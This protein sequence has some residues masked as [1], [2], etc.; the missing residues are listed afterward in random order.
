MPVA[1][2]RIQSTVFVPPKAPIAVPIVGCSLEANRVASNNDSFLR[3][4]GRG[5]GHVFGAY[6]RPLPYGTISSEAS[7]TASTSTVSTTSSAIVTIPRIVRS[8]RRSRRLLP[9]KSQGYPL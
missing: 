7:S 8:L 6:R 5:V 1:I 3:V 2:V 4:L 9:F